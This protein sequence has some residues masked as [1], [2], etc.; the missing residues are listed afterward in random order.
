[1][2]HVAAF[3]QWFQKLLMENT[4]SH[5]KKLPWGIL[6]N[7][8]Y[9]YYHGNFDPLLIYYHGKNYHFFIPRRLFWRSRIDGSGRPPC[10]GEWMVKPER[11]AL[12]II[13]WSFPWAIIRYQKS[14][15]ITNFKELLGGFEHLLFSISDMGCHPSHWRTPSFFK[16][17]KTQQPDHCKPWLYKHY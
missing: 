4:H 3:F 17:V 9:I 15:Q 1:M 2:S 6:Q 7:T 11:S 8:Y 16:M 10:H 5:G 12:L 14:D 13:T